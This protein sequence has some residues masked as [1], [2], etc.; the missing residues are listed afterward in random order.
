MPAGRSTLDEDQKDREKT[1]QY[2]DRRC[3]RKALRGYDGHIAHRA[4]LVLKLQV[5][6]G[7]DTRVFSV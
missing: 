7:Y 2:P 3:H 5:G 4:P 1:G 6:R